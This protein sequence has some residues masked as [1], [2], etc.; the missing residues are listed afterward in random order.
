[1]EVRVELEGQVD[2]PTVCTMS[3]AALRAVAKTP[4]VRAYVRACV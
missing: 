3:S 2:A 4:Q 1:M